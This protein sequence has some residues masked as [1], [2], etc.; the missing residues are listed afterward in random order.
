VLSFFFLDGRVWMRNYQINWKDADKELTEDK[1]VE[2]GAIPT[3]CCCCCCCC[4][5]P[6]GFLQSFLPVPA[7]PPLVPE[8]H[9]THS[10]PRCVLNP[11]R[12][13]A[14]T[15]GGPTLF[16]NAE[17]ISPNLVG[18]VCLV[19]CSLCHPCTDTLPT[20][21]LVCHSLH[22]LSFETVQTRSLARREAAGKY[23]SRHEAKVGRV[24]RA[25]THVVP[26]D[27]VEEVFRE[28]FSMKP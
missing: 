26:A 5:S 16:E 19:L 3:S 9:S 23:K 6:R 22:A 18:P 17:Y 27:P 8:V 1:L 28:S 25:A 4:C 10:G 24:E 15:F 11:I 20:L 14:G 13:F 7:R 12:I 21:W 2:I